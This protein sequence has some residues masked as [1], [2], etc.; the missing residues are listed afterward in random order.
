[1]PERPAIHNFADHQSRFG[2]QVGELFD[3]RS[4]SCVNR[5][6]VIRECPRTGNEQQTA[7]GQNAYQPF[8]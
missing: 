1:M 4:Q 8:G 6:R 3:I 2:K 5:V 7:Q